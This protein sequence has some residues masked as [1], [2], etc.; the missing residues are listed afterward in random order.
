MKAILRALFGKRAVECR[1]SDEDHQAMA[2]LQFSNA[3]LLDEVQALSMELRALIEL[4]ERFANGAVRGTNP[5]KGKGRGD[6]R[7]DGKDNQR[8]GQG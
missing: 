6:G 4:E 1:L 8:K 5:E 7:L 3:V 2:A